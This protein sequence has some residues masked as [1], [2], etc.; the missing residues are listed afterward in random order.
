MAPN[1]TYMNMR[2]AGHR[3]IEVPKTIE[4]PYTLENIA[5]ATGRNAKSIERSLR[6][7]T[8]RGRVERFQDGWHYKE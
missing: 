1:S 2:A 8:K 6:R 4:L 7:L 5:N 3:D